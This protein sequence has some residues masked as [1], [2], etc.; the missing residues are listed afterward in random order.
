MMTGS[1]RFRDAGAALVIAVLAGLL[2]LA[3][4]LDR[5]LCVLLEDLEERGLLESTVVLAMGE[6]GRTNKLPQIFRNHVRLN[7]P[8]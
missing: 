5:T 2:I 3:P 1:A 6:F 8:A 7:H 4:P